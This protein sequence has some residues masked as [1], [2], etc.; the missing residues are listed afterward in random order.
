M[1]S[2]DFHRTLC[3]L[4]SAVWATDS[5]YVVLPAL[6]FHN[7]SPYIHIHYKI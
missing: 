1:L 7:K 6:S 3:P 2:I 4:F 5:N